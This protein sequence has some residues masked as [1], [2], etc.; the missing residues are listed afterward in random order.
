[1]MELMSTRDIAERIGC[2]VQYIQKLV[3]QGKLTPVTPKVRGQTMWFERGTIDRFMEER[4]ERLRKRQ[5][6]S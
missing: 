1:M 2:S 6:K 3:A 5:V 4:E